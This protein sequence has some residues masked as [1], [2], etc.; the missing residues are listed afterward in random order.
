M[1]NNMTWLYGILYNYSYCY[2]VHLILTPYKSINYELTNLRLS[3][4]YPFHSLHIWKVSPSFCI[5]NLH[6][7]IRFLWLRFPNNYTAALSRFLASPS[8]SSFWKSRLGSSLCSSPV[9]DDWT[10]PRVNQGTHAHIHSTY[11]GTCTHQG[12][13]NQQRFRLPPLPQ[14]KRRGIKLLVTL[15]PLRVVMSGKSRRASKCMG[16]TT[17]AKHLLAGRDFHGVRQAGVSWHFC[18]T[19]C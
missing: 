12:H 8:S 1:Y 5:P 10:G 17:K 4:S 15:P 19:V 18:A 13:Y 16:D 3:T 9:D 14:C 11:T 6:L 7:G 2:C